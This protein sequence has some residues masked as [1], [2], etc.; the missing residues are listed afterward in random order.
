LERACR[1]RRSSTTSKPV[2]RSRKRKRRDLLAL[3]DE[4]EA[5][6]ARGEG[7][8]ITEESMKALAEE[9]KQRVRQRIVEEG[10]KNS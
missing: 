6:L 9:I 10:F 4:A 5:S 1:S 3:I 8:E 2:S 7:R